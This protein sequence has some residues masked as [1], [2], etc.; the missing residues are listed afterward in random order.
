M[1]AFSAAGSAI[2]GGDGSELRNRR[3]QVRILS[4]AL[5]EGAQ[6]ALECEISWSAASR[7]SRRSAHFSL[8]CLKVL[9]RVY[10]A[11]RNCRAIAAGVEPGPFA[12]AVFKMR[13]L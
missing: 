7:V 10:H 6:T 12:R 3:S 11:D 2:G 8:P 13:C 9:S 5:G 4:G 1:R